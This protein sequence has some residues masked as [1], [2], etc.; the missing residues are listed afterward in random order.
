MA[1]KARY[2]KLSVM[3]TGQ[4]V[5]DFW[6]AVSVTAFPELR[7]FGAKFISHFGTT[8]RCEQAFSTMKF[9]KSNYR[10]W[11]TRAH[12]EALMKLAVTDS[13]PRLENLVKKVQSQGSH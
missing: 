7:S 12:Q 3:I 10:T 13:Q 9:V 2:E 4:D 5:V 11:L 1:L 6:K 8:Y